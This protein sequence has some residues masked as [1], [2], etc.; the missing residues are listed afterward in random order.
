MTMRPTMKKISACIIASV[1]LSTGA[2]AH[3]DSDQSCKPTP[4]TAVA[5]VKAL[6]PA[7]RQFLLDE[8]PIADPGGKF[9]P[10]GI[11]DNGPVPRQRLMSA[12]AGTDCVNVM[13]K[14]GDRG[15]G[16]WKLNFQRVDGQWVFASQQWQH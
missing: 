12:V 2:A 11:I 9:H 13:V 1:A 10:S 7:V 16:V 3:A 5:T 8:G 6:P 14:R 4:P 15:D